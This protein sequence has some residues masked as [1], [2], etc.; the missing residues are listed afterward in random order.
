MWVAVLGGHKVVVKFLCC[1][2]LLRCLFAGCRRHRQRSVK[3]TFAGSEK[4]EAVWVK[5]KV[6]RDKVFNWRGMQQTKES[7]HSPLVS[8][9]TAASPLN[10][11]RKM[12]CY[13]A[14]H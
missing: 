9:F 5:T 12:T 7:V 1:K 11:K 10:E 13:I 6:G 2:D 14:L 4:S 3:I 8:A